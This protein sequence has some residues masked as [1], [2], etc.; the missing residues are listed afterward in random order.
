MYCKYLYLLLLQRKCAL[1]PVTYGESCTLSPNFIQF[2]CLLPCC[3][4]TKSN[5]Q[6]VTFIL[7]IGEEADEKVKHVGLTC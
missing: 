1:S 6:G 3:H 5:F 4:S 2:Y 7:I